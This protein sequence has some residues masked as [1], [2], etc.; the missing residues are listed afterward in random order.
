[1]FRGLDVWAWLSCRWRLSPSV[2]QP[3]KDRR[4]DIVGLAQNSTESPESWQKAME[5]ATRQVETTEFETARNLHEEWWA[6][7]WNRSWIH[8]SGNTDATKV[9]QGYCIQRWMMACSSRGE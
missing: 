9:S 1:M 4:V 3:H 6:R 5:A 7:F 2:P 8:I